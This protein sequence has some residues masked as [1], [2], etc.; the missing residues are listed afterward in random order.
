MSDAPPRTG[1]PRVAVIGGGWAGLS[2]AARLHDAGVD[3]TVFEAAKSLGGRARRVP[4][5]TRDGRSI[6]LDNGQHILIGAYRE[7]L[8]L[9]Q[10]LDVDLDRA[11]ERTP[12]HLIAAKGMRLRAARLPAPWHLVSM[13]VT[14]RGLS[15]DE[16][17]A[18]ASLMSRAKKIRWTL[19]IDVT[20]GELLAAWRQPRG[21]THK[22]WEPL[23]VAALNTPIAIASAQVFLNVL[24]D[25]LGGSSADSD[26]LLPRV[27]LGHLL[28]DAL[29]ARVGPAALRLSARIQNIAVDGD[30]VAV[31][32]GTATELG[33]PERFDGAVLAVPPVDAGRL[34]ASLA[35]HEP[36]Y[37]PLVAAC[38]AFVFQPIVTAYLRYRDPPRWP[39]RMLAL[40]AAPH[41]DRHAQWA[42]DRSERLATDV[43]H[44]APGAGTGLVAAVI[45]AE[46]PHRELDHDALVASIA[47]QLTTECDLPSQPLEARVIVEKRATYASTPSLG[48][49]DVTTPHARLVL[50]GDYV[51]EADP[52]RH[53]PATLE[54]AVASGRRAAEALIA[55]IDR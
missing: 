55:A 28:P 12:L 38:D 43:H 30:G 35:R 11:F 36:R 33:Q 45:S 44:A 20:V 5:T 41:V 7:T 8:T 34:L 51:G 29:A 40:D 4:W 54:A 52:V 18:I 22:L 24:R 21:L 25:S 1:P 3:C 27:D 46:G 9:M 2:A 53:Y 48:R 32:G 31:T 37:R 26:L 17:I 6:A 19:G 50:A 42:F 13:I 10:R 15:F 39:S 23:C 14:A 47:R 49:V 16:R